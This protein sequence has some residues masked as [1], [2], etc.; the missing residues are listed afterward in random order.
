MLEYYTGG[1]LFWGLGYSMAIIGGLFLAGVSLLVMFLI[2]WERKVAGHV[3]SRLGPMHVGGWHGWAQ[4]IA[5]GIKLLFKE[6]LM[7]AQADRF[8]FRL[9]PYLA[10]APVFAAMLALPFGPQLIFEKGLNIGVIYILAVL[11][12]EVMGTILAGWGSNSKWSIYGAMREACQM[13]SYEIP[14]GLAILTA[15]L[16]AG[17]LNMM[18][19]AYLQGAG[20]WGWFIFANPFIFLAFSLYF[21]AS[22]ASSKRAPFDLPESE[23]ELVA[24]F[25]TEYSGL[26]WSLF[27]FAE[28]AGMF[29]IGAIQATLFLGAWNSP[30][31]IYDP[32]YLLI[33][34]DP[35]AAGQAFFAGT[36]DEASRTAGL[37]GAA[38]AMGLSVFGL[39]VLNL[40]GAALF[41][42]K[43]IL[44]VW[45]QM[46]LRWTLPRIRIDQVLHLCVKVLL[47]VSLVTLVGS[48]VWIVLVDGPTVAEGADPR[49]AHLLGD[50]SV[51]AWITRIILTIL[52]LLIVAAVVGVVALAWLGI[53]LRDRRQPRKSLFETIMPV[54]NSVAFYRN[55]RDTPDQTGR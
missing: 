49:L 25:L 16:A 14:L 31:G 11:G 26:R 35:I 7:P 18:E 51:V 27:F 10:F 32:I 20:I 33:G 21:I 8:L 5:D 42:G 19:L 4:S 55:Y 9:A 36:I 3:Q 53:I 46:W 28:Y 2:W 48:A 13:V 17:T 29:I 34:Y 50:I 15:V 40:Y 45:V 52:G 54:S 23:S 47:P 43:A 44:V 39:I 1:S 22:L 24:G 30:L 6:D 12:V 38:D 41:C 37:S